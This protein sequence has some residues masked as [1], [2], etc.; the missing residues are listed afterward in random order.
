MSESRHTLSLISWRGLT[1]ELGDEQLRGAIQHILRVTPSP[2]KYIATVPTS[3]GLLVMNA[4]Q[5]ELD[6]ADPGDTY[7]TT[8]MKCLRALSKERSVFPSSLICE[9]IVAKGDY[10]V[11]GGGLADIWEGRM[12]GQAVCLKVLRIFGIPKPQEEI[13]L[14]DLCYEAL[15]WRQ[16]HHEN[17]VPF[18]GVNFDYFKPKFCLVAP[19]M[20][21]GNIIDYLELHPNHN[22]VKC[23][24]EI[25]SAIEYLHSL[26]P[27]VIHGDIRG[28]NVLVSDDLRCCLADFGASV[29]MA[30]QA[31]SSNTMN[32][33]PLPWLAPELQEYVSQS[34][35][36]AFLPGRDIYAFGCTVIEIFTLERPYAHLRPSAILEEIQQGKRH[37]RPPINV[38]PSDELWRLVEKCME[39]D[40]SQRPGAK[41]VKRHLESI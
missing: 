9:T 5:K 41:D 20:K 23:V 19:W 38:L 17:I 22:R 11:A 34:Y 4:L 14:K 13:L 29:I 8:C 15:V 37:P 18:L 7:H 2:W 1:S 10:P 12:N 26:D 27:Q 32:E 28:C 6:E 24:Y 39:K 25:A 35:D 30:T 16:L 40:P 21:N 31:P 3:V 33:S 36:Q